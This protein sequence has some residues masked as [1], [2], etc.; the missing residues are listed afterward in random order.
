MNAL[1]SLIRPS[2]TIKTNFLFSFGYF[3]HCAG[4]LTGLVRARVPSVAITVHN[5]A[6]FTVTD[7]L[8]CL[9]NGDALSRFVVSMPVLIALLQAPAIV[10]LRLRLP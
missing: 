6:Q 4:M 1:S 10:T 7:N 8:P 5:I 9:V 3:G 2:H